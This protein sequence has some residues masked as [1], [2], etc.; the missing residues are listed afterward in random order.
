MS[1]IAIACLTVAAFAYAVWLVVSRR[2]LPNPK[3]CKGLQRRFVLAT[4]LF[5]GL[6]AATLSKAGKP[7]E[8]ICYVA[9]APRQEIQQPTR[10]QQVTAALKAIWRMLDPKRAEE[11][12]NRLEAVAAEGKLRKK[13]AD[14]LAVAFSELAFHKQRTRGK[15]PH[16]TCYKM[17]PLGGTLYT[18]RENALKQ[19][20]LL[21][22]A[23]ES[24]AIDAETAAKAHSILAKE[25]EMLHRAKALM[26]LENRLAQGRL[27]DLYKA[28]K[29][30]PGDNDVKILQSRIPSTDTR[31]RLKMRRVCRA[32]IK[33]GSVNK[34]RTKQV[35]EVIGIP[36]VG[37]LEE[38]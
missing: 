38:K 11:F 10:Y 24:G 22:N 28:E 1:K 37:T 32:L 29:I 20:E 7:P 9:P 15:G 2:R 17:T 14:M 30:V 8:V 34:Q 26:A 23:R 25:V 19:L 36:L 27:T 6:L 4:L 33:Y 12:R 3:N 5:V 16:V 18:T 21:A 31:Y 35:E 13:T